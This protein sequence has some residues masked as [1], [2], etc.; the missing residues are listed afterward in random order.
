MPRLIFHIRSLAH[1]GDIWGSK[2]DRKFVLSDCSRRFQL[3]RCAVDLFFRRTRLKKAYVWP[4]LLFQR[5]KHELA[6]RTGPGKV[7]ISE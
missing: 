3:V 4:S 6:V 1:G 2:H 7:T 5:P